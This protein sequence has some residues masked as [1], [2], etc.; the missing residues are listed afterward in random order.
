MKGS[1]KLLERRNQYLKTLNQNATGAQQEPA[2]APIATQEQPMQQVSHAQQN[3]QQP[4][5]IAR[6][7]LDHLRTFNSSTDSMRFTTEVFPQ[8]SQANSLTFPLG[9]FI[10]PLGSTVR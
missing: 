9:I 2:P 7:S 6:P 4:S 3:V 5:G 8:L 1:S 10:K